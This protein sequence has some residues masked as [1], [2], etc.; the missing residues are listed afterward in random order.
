MSP[1]RVELV[2]LADAAALADRA[3]EEVLRCA[4]QAVAERGVFRIALSGG[5]TPKA[6]YERLAAS[7]E[8]AD[9]ARWHVF[10]G[11]ERC[12]PPEHAESNFGMARAA[13][14]GK[15]SCGA[16]YRVRGE[17]R[18]PHEAAREYEKDLEREFAP[19]APRF[20][21]VLLGLGADG[22]TASLFPGSSAVREN[23][24]LV[25]ATHVAKFNAHRITFTA[26]L[27]N[28][29]RCVMFLVAGG[30]KSPALRAVMQGR[31]N[32]PAGMVL[33]LNGK[34]LWLVDRAAAAGLVEDE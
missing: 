22:H 15:A 25:V 28:A 7:A 34:L 11:D 18:D 4:A 19:Q 1:H 9:F 8:R 14:L 20:D 29:A 5:S 16:V 6:L 13:W 31:D 24:K 30:D 23:A 21:L 3:R 2:A 32:L 33:P 26:P 17:L 10:F 27:I 12:V